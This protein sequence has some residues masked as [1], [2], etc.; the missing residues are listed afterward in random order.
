MH[1][2]LSAERSSLVAVGRHR[3]W[4]DTVSTAETAAG[5]RSTTAILLVLAAMF[6]FAV[7]DGLTKILA[8]KLAIPQ[9][10]WVRNIVFAG[11]AIALLRGQNRDKPLLS[12][13]HSN[14]PWLQFWRALLLIV[15]SGVFM[16]AF[17]LMP[18]ADVHAV[19]A[20]A[21][22]LVVALSVPLL[23]EH[24]G[25]RRWAAVVVGFI[26]V[27][28]IIRP[29]FEKIEPP[30]LIALLG[31]AMWALYQIMVRLCSRVD[32]SET[33]SLWTALVGLGASTLIGPVSWV[34]PDA[35]GWAML[36]AIAILGSVS[37]I[38]LIRALGMMEPA[39]LQ[40]YNYTLFVWAVVVGYL[41]FGDI[42]DRWTLAGAA[43]IIVS[44]LYV[45]H[46]ERVR[47]AGKQ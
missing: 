5:R 18:L 26:G 34:W 44:G 47:A 1:R 6:A 2:N 13:A 38:A 32:R 14:R 35:T 12:L 3:R 37:H 45:W 9:I 19:N 10:L 11:L 20:V 29:G 41:F 17:S 46:R 4:N 8:Q 30:V 15:E 33:T 28:L 43:I 24:V 22:L 39:L 7:M 25:P 23:G 42:P 31:S 21:P 40:P 36:A 27:L 16:V